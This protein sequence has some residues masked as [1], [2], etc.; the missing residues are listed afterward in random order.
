MFLMATKT[1]QAL[2]WVVSGAG[3][4]VG[5][6]TVCGRLCE[7]LPKSVYVKYG[8]GRP[9]KHKQPNYFRD[10]DGLEEFVAAARKRAKHVVVEC[11]VWAHDGRGDVTIFIDASPVRTGMRDDV[12]ALRSLA[13]L[14]VCADSD[15]KQWRKVLARVKISA[16]CRA[17]VERILSEQQRFVAG[18]EAVT[19]TKVWFEAG[20]EHVFG[21]GIAGLLESIDHL[22]T[23][24]AAAKEVHMSYRYAW[25]LLR[26][27]EAHFGR[28]FVVRHV[29][30]RRGGGTSL[31]D[32]GRHA[33]AVFRRLNKDVADF[34]DQ[35]F[36]DLY[37]QGAMNG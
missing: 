10:L 34:A 25:Q 26:A 13:D 32:E 30:G 11:N 19:R 28:A 7:V 37:G 22:K 4:N 29:G 23:L 36:R 27:A 2:I 16:A 14:C 15:P 35:R 6:T 18:A 17:K 3:R 24:T 33:L 21:A 20:G 5:K 12:P 1:S 31:T 9:K 8:H